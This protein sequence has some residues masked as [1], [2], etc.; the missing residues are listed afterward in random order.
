VTAWNIMKFALHLNFISE[1]NV[2]RSEF[3]KMIP[4][5][6]WNYFGYFRFGA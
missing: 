3:V 5:S 4:C 2:V 6:K 1:N